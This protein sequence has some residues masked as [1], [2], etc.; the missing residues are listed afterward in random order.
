VLSFAMFVI[1][2]TGWEDA[3]RNVVPRRD[4]RAS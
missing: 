4:G 2:V 3:T 1:I